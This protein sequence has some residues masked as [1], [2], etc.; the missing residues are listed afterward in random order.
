M[1]D[2]KTIWYVGVNFLQFSDDT[3]VFS[4]LENKGC[5]DIML[6]EASHYDFSYDNDWDLQETFKASPT[7]YSG[8]TLVAEDDEYAVVSNHSV[9]GTYSIF[10]KVTEEELLEEIERQ[11]YMTGEIGA[12]D[13]QKEEDGHYEKVYL[14]ED[15]I[16]L[17]NS[18][19]K[20]K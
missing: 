17:I 3:E 5:Y 6:L 16:K 18:K 14:S 1:E 12:Y 20:T 2:K 19:F 4:E 13:Y 7:H 11:G 10:R 8:D 9:G 15:V